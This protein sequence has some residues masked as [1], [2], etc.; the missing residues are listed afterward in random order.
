MV[1]VSVVIELGVSIRGVSVVLSRSLCATHG[2]GKSFAFM[3]NAIAHTTI[4]V[5][6]TTALDMC[7]SQQV[8]EAAVF[9]R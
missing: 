3:R 2:T 8:V 5:N 6:I 9:L 7:L 1:H 4:R